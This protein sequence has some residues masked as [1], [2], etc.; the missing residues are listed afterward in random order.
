M[1]LIETDRL[2]MYQFD[3]SHAKYI[4]RLNHDPDVMKYTADVFFDSVEQAIEKIK[5]YDH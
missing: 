3:E 4:F 2:K 1:T 5:T